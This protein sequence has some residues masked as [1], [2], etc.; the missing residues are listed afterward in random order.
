MKQ[1][2]KIMIDLDVVTMA[3]WDKSHNGDIGR[4]FLSRTEEFEIVTPFYLLGHLDKWKHITLKEQI[5]NFYLK[6]S[7]T[8]LT[9]EDIDYE[10]GNLGIDDVKILLELQSK[11]VKEEDAFIVLVTSIFKLDY[12]VTFN[13]KHLRG[14]EK[15]INEILR[16]NGIK[17][18]KIAGPEEA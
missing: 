10:I 15:E 6:N 11:D 16:K 5:E 4:E 1:K 2:K 12:L 9:N 14:K 3:K 7:T 18:I 8:L 17:T 13:R